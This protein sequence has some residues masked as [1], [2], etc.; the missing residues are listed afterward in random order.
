MQNDIPISSLKGIDKTIATMCDKNG[1]GKL[2]SMLGEVS[3]FNKV[4][5]TVKGDTFQFEGK[6]YNKDGTI[7]YIMK[8]TNESVFTIQA[9]SDNQCQAT[10][11]K[12]SKTNTD[13]SQ[14]LPDFKQEKLPPI[15]SKP[16]STRVA[17]PVIS[18]P[19][20]MKLSSDVRTNYNWSVE[21]FEGVI[22]KM[23]PKSSVLRGRAKDFIDAAKA[24]GVDPRFL[25]GIAMFESGGGTSVRAKDKHDVG[26]LLGRKFTSVSQSIQ[27]IAKTIST[28]YGKGHKSADSIAFPYTRSKAS[29]PLWK[30]KVVEFANLATKYYK[31]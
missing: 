3:I 18:R 16:V 2:Q 1:D 19:V 12:T 5:S 14:K 27:A 29:A 20:P 21:A 23:T 8:P 15:T 13:K 10:G 7:N 4:K 28:N 11:D 9:N 25:L 30:R 31:A 22:D 26:G 6:V 24:N 17:K